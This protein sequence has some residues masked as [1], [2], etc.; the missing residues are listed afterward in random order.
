[1]NFFSLLLCLVGD[2]GDRDHTLWST[3]QVRQHGYHL[4][5]VSW[6]I[7]QPRLIPGKLIGGVTVRTG[8]CTW[9]YCLFFWFRFDSG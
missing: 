1:M 5:S 9:N 8:R 4:F 7:T 2:L 6:C 3:S